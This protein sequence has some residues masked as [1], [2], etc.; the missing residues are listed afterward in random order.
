MNNSRQKII[1][2][3][4]IVTE[5]QK[6]I[7]IEAKGSNFVAL[8]PF[9]ADSNPSMSISPEKKIFKCF[10]C[11]EGGDVVSFVSKYERISQGAAIEKVAKENKI[12]IEMFSKKVQNTPLNFL[13]NDISTFYQSALLVTPE[14]KAGLNYLE[15]RNISM[16]AI[17]E[18]KLGYGYDVAEKL[19]EYLEK[20]INTENKYSEIDIMEINHFRNKMDMFASRL[21]IPIINAG[22]IV[23]FGARD[24]EGKNVKYINSKDSKVFKKG[25]V[26]Y[27]LEAALKNTIDKTLI[28]TEGYF[29]VI[30]A[31]QNGVKNCCALMGTSFTKQHLEKLK[32]KINTVYL[33]LDSDEAGKQSMLKIGAL[34]E[35]ENF[36]VKIINI[37][38]AKDL[39]EYFQTHEV[40]D[41]EVLLKSSDVYKIFEMKSLAT[42]FDVNNYEQKEQYLRRIMKNLDKKNLL[43]QN[44]VTSFLMSNFDVSLEYLSTLKEKKVV[45]NNVNKITSNPQVNNNFID[46][47]DRLILKMIESKGQ[48]EE[49]LMLLNTNNVDINRNIELFK[50]IKEYYLEYD[51][52]DYVLFSDMNINNSQLLQ[53]V[54]N[55]EQVSDVLTGE[56]LIKEL[57]KR[58]KGF[59]LGGLK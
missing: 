11:G 25:E 35:D 26:I 16:E 17:K 53:S 13:I 52:F 37:P 54:F 34:L 20:K 10:V 21:I 47:E 22:H 19:Y 27:N 6:Y 56:Q 14:G 51:E 15:K 48:Y 5:I 23:G 31:H 24:I 43:L 40:R 12:K 39:D 57:K 9:H 36:D 4:D 45:K 8:C 50:N 7:D 2:N 3:V 41:F 30:T 49:I 18:F 44:D 33:A 1:D 32:G 42:S 28:I 38:T 55:K 59:N 29:D 58:K 46:F